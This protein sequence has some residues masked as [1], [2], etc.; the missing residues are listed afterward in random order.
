MIDL[1]E[2]LSPYDAWQRAYNDTKTLVNVCEGI[3]AYKAV[4]DSL[5]SDAV[6]GKIPYSLGAN[7]YEAIRLAVRSYTVL[8]IES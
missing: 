2:K 7:A 4:L 3:V 6:L 1:S 5:D 8:R